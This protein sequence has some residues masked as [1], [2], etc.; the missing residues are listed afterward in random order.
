MQYYLID[1]TGLVYFMH[2]SLK[3][4]YKNAQSKKYTII[5]PKNVMSESVL[6]I[7]FVTNHITEGIIPMN[8]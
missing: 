4:K 8:H 3:L 2:S 5:I 7:F 6:P 1:S